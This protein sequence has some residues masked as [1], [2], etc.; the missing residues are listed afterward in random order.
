MDELSMNQ[1]TLRSEDLNALITELR[2]HFHWLDA[3]WIPLERPLHFDFYESWIAQN[4]HGEMDYLRRHMPLKERPEGL[5]AEARSL[6][7]ISKSYVP[8]PKPHGK[9]PGLRLAR[10]AQNHDYH[11]W[12]G[13]E[14]KA[15]A[16]FLEERLPGLR[17]RSGVD[18]LPV[19]E[20]DHAARA[21]LGW[22]GKNSCL[23]DRKEGSFFFLGEILTTAKVETEFAAPMDFCGSCQRC[24]EVCPTGAILETRTLDARK[25]IS[26]WT[27]ES[28]ST[29]PPALAE[30]FGDHFFGCDICQTV[31]PW[32]QKAF[33]GREVLEVRPRLDKTQPALEDLRWLLSAPDDEIKKDLK[34]SPLG[35][36]KVFGLRRNA[37]IVAAN[38]EYT[39]LL[40]ELEKYRDDEH[41]GPLATWAIQKLSTKLSPLLVKIQFATSKD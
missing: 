12:F 35:R 6:L 36:A 3:R 39:E 18:T 17:C 40:P 1:Q 38:S 16:S 5:L 10:Y 11:E 14:L 23:I 24:I 8:A 19:M 7:V 21:G 28:K 20:R 41:L 9:L 13:D 32:N 29:P 33:K 15:A 25:C 31:C 27:I 4:H 37:M 34:D 30:K 26:Y 22:I 2:T